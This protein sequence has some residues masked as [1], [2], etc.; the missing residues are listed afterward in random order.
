MPRAPKL[1]DY[2]VIKVME[3]LCSTLQEYSSCNLPYAGIVGKAE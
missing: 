3:Y 2:S 1:N